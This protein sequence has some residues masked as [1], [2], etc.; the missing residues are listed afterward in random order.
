M[1]HAWP[2]YWDESKN[3]WI[4]IDP[5]WGSTTGGINF[6]DQLDLRHFAFVA[7]GQDPDKPYPAGSYKLGENPQKD[8]YISFGQL[9]DQ[10]VIAAEVSYTLSPFR[11]AT[12]RTLSVFIKNNGPSAHE[13]YTLTLNVDGS[14]NEQTL[15]VPPYTSRRVDF[16][17]KDGFFGEYTPQS[18]QL[19]TPL[20]TYTIPTQIKDVILIN[21]LIGGSAILLLVTIIL[22]KTGKLKIRFNIRETITHK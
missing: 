1:L 6:F 7:H 13:N 22:H 21:L 12:D 19:T 5:T 10:K 9:P 2:E 16:A 8:V 11:P 17:I 18:I 20:E 3:A 14:L 4:P 15:T